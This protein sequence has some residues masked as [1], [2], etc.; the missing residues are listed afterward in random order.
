MPPDLHALHAIHDAT[1]PQHFE[2]KTQ[3]NHRKITVTKRHHSWLTF[4]VMKC[5]NATLKDA[6]H[7]SDHSLQVRS[8]KHAANN[9]AQFNLVPFPHLD[10]APLCN[11]SLE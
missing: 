8:A 7:S 2:V 5:T 6:L 9:E 11:P 4:L 10:N 1:L 3:Q